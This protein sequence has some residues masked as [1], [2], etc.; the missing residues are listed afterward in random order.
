MYCDDFAIGEVTS[1]DVGA[2]AAAVDKGD[3]C[4]QDSAVGIGAQVAQ[5]GLRRCESRRLP[6]S[7]SLTVRS[8]LDLATTF[9]QLVAKLGLDVLD[10]SVGLCVHAAV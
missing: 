3:V 6:V 8:T 5:V 1:E 7:G 4:A 10:E 2:D 9:V